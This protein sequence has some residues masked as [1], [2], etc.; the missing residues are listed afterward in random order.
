MMELTEGS[1]RYAVEGGILGEE[2]ARK[3]REGK[4]SEIHAW[5]G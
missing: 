1:D 2:P 4:I 5:L 3:L